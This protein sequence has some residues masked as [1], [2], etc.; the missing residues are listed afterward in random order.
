M[1]KMILIDNYTMSF[2]NVK[3]YFDIIFLAIK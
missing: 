2:E 1:I 3:L